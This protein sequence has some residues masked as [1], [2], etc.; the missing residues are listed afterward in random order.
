MLKCILV[1]D[2]IDQMKS[3][4][5][6]KVAG[7]WLCSPVLGTFSTMSSPMADTEIGVFTDKLGQNSGISAVYRRCAEDSPETHKKLLS[8]APRTRPQGRAVP[9]TDRLSSGSN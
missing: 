4:A 2:W 8:A 5:F 3:K 9:N 1:V 6:I 7:R